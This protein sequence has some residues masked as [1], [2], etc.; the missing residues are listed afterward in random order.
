[1]SDLY[2][3]S[4]KGKEVFTDIRESEYLDLLDQWAIEFYQTGTPHP[5]DIT[6]TTRRSNLNE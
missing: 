6:F 4:I 3:V 1:M 5:D 2:T